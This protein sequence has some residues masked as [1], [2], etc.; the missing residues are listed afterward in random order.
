MTQTINIVNQAKT[1]LG[2]DLNAI[3]DACQWYVDACLKPIWNVSATIKVATIP[4]ANAIN[5]LLLDTSDVEG[6]LGYHDLESGLPIARIFIKT[7]LENGEIVSGTISHELAEL[8]VDP[9]CQSLVINNDTGTV[10]P[11]EVCD[12]VEESMF[13]APNGIQLSDF[14]YPEW[15]QEWSPAGTQFDYM[16]VLT[17]A[18]QLDK[19]G[20][21]TAIQEGTITT[22]WGSEAKKVRWQK[23]DRRGH[24]LE[25]LFLHNVIH[26][27]IAKAPRGH[28]TRPSPR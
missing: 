8:L 13:S 23:E 3:V 2:Q 27:G 14:V 17:G 21:I 1:P 6:A 26:A 10:Y 11:Y 7:A 25:E 19:G 5:M 12:A 4:I 24:R 20:Y 22:L 28:K 15:F 9:F 18:F 16:K